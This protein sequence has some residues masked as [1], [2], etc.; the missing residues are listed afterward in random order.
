MIVGA[1]PVAVPEARG[2]VPPARGRRVLRARRRRLRPV[3][4]RGRR[5][6]R[7]RGDGARPAGRRDRGRRPPRR[8]RGRRDR[9][10]R[11]A[12]RSGGAARRRSSA[13]SPTPTCASAWAAA[14][15]AHVEARPLL[16]GRYRRRRRP[17]RSRLCADEQAR[18]DHRCRRTGRLAARRAPARAGLR[19]LRRRPPRRRRS[20]T[21]TSTPS[22]TASS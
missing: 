2:F 20:A 16:V 11:P 5:L 1:G 3:A 17:V 6:D 15:R 4:P 10:A 13:C 14:A 18:P 12:G 21:R 8:D 22:A 9:P 19:G 7:A